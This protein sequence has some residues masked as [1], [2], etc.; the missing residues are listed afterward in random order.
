MGVNVGGD[1][2]T[3]GLLLLLDAKNNKSYPGSGTT[4][5]NLA[6]IAGATTLVNTSYNSNGYL[7]FNGSS[8][9]ASIT[10][11]NYRP[12]DQITYEILVYFNNTTTN[13]RFFSDWAQ[14]V[15][16]DR[17]MFWTSGSN[18][19]WYMK[20]TT[21]SESGISFP[22]SS[23]NWYHLVG[24]YNGAKSILYVNGD[25]Y[26]EQ[27][28]T[29]TLSAGTSGIRLGNNNGTNWLNGNIAK[30]AIYNRALTAKEVLFNYKSIVGRF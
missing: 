6:P 2:S 21:T 13:V 5:N 12:T 3:N 23:G 28:R 11:T 9:Y 10:A 17:C 16:N 22:Y 15:T 14:N 25:Y 18:I 8:S 1:M 27:V 19:Q 29:G 24:T 4:W 30:L 20:T 7:T 26:T